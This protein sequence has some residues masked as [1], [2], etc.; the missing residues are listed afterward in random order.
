LEAFGIVLLE[1]MS[2]QTPVLAFDTPGVN[3]V[4]KDGGM[5]FSETTELAEQILE[6]HKDDSRRSAL[7]ERGRRTVEE[8]YSWAKVLDKIESIY[9]EVTQ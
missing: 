1:A 7:G 8:K 4:A 2:C 3:E 9:D 6:L 5:I